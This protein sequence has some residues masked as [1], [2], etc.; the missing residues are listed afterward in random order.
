MSDLAAVADQMQARGLEPP[1]YLMADGKVRRFGPKKRC[2]YV[3]KETR[4][5]NGR[6]V[7]VGSFGDWAN[8]RWRV[9]VD[10]KGIGE[11]ERRQLQ[12][13][14]DAA[15]QRERAERERA[16]AW[17]AMSASELWRRGSAAGASPYLQRKGVQ[18]ESCRYLWDGTLLVPLLRY[19]LPREQALR[20]VQTIRPDGTKRF[21]KGFQKPGCC[22]RL[23]LV[24]LGEPLLVC[25]GYATGLS[26]RAALGQRYPVFGALDAGNL[27]PV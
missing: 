9:E 5:S 23:G 27:R 3:L 20:A 17:A 14:R 19:D 8:G 25:E 15:R 2:W 24:A 26:L 22:V 21:T 4:M 11:D 12:A 6:H 1:P 7:V 18:G 13:L 10:W 16:A